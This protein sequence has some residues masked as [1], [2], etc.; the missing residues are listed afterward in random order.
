MSTHVIIHNVTSSISIL[1]RF[2]FYQIS[3]LYFIFF[4]IFY[5]RTLQ[6]SAISKCLKDYLGRKC[7]QEAATFVK[8]PP[9]VTCS[10]SNVIGQIISVISVLIINNLVA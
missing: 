8:S 7:S 1:K 2:F 9:G 3:K 10:A 6:E 4:F 5:S